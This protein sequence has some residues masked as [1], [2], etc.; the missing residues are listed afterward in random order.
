MIYSST[1]NIQLVIGLTSSSTD[2][3]WRMLN[4]NAFKIQNKTSTNAYADRVVISSAG[5]VGIGTTT[6][7]RLAIGLGVGTTGTT[8]IRWFNVNA[9]LTQSFVGTAAASGISLYVLGTIWIWGTVASS[10]DCRIKEDIQDI[11]DDSVLNMILAI[12][13]KTYKYID[14][15]SRGYNKVYGFI[16]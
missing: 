6:D 4:D 16:A 15:L 5:Y 7:Y 12:E 13:P 1:P 14:K 11:N 8:T 3:N 10:S 9:P 2:F